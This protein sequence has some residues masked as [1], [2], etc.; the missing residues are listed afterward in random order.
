MSITHFTLD[1][2]LTVLIEPHPRAQSAALA[3]LT[4]AGSIYEEA[5]CNGTAAALADWM[6]RGAGARDSRELIGA[7][8]ALGVEAHESAG[9][10]FLSLTAA[11]LAE[12]LIPA[13]ELY[14]DVLLRPRLPEDQLEAVLGGI[15]QNLLAMEDEPQRRV[16]VELRRRVFDDPWG[17]SSDG[18]LADLERITPAIVHTH[19]ERN[20]RPNGT[21]I[22]ISGRVDPQEAREAIER[23]LGRWEVRPVPEIHSRPPQETDEFLEF[24]AAQT[25]IGLSYP[26]VPYGHPD[27]YSAWAAVDVLS[28][29]SSSRLFTE[30]REKRGLCYSVD[31]SLT[32]LL[33]EGCVMAYAG[34]TTERAQETLDVMLEVFRSL[35]QGVAPDELRRCQAR[36]KSTLIM[37]QESTQSRASAIV[38]DW[39]HLGRVLPLEEI[40]LQLEQ[41]SVE[42][43]VDYA[44]RYPPEP[45]T[46]FCVGASPLRFR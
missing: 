28:G 32:S 23:I 30:V 11:T 34:T 40:R 13:L 14:G 22:G 3:I 44:R 45:V 6:L 8:D 21:L 9:W 26:A 4:P 2:G 5:G 18:S 31:A 37:Q 27:Y 46:G 16:F 33:T 24:P 38:R 10:N 25:H 41:L 35:E 15:E 36:A 7:L 42:Q 39:F 19:Y 1:N 43:V 20:V 29:G 12:N 17:R